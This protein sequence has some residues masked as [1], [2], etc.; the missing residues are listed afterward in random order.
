M[1]PRPPRRAARL[2]PE[3]DDRGI[4]AGPA[5]SRDRDHLA[6]H[7][8]SILSNPPEEEADEDGGTA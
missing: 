6:R 8:I 5:T 7:I 3:S 2:V 4:P 1:R